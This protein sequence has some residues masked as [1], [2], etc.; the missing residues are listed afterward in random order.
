MNKS[1]N[2]RQWLTTSAAC[3]GILASG[4]VDVESAPSTRN[5]DAGPIPGSA[6]AASPRRPLPDMA[7]AKWVWYPAGRTL[8]NTF[9]LFRREIELNAPPRSARGWIAADSR[10]RLEVN[11][12]RI[13]WGPAPADPRW[14]EADPVD[15]TGV[16]RAGKNVLG[17]TVLYY[18]QGDG[19]WPIG[20]P[21][22]LCR[23]EI[24]HADGR[25][26]V[27]ASDESWRALLCRAWQPGH[28]KRWYLRA[29]QEEFDARLY[30]YGW[31]RAD[32]ATNPDW[33]AAMPLAGSPNGPALA[34]QYG[35]Y[36]L[37]ID[38]GPPDVE[39][40]PRSIPLVTESMVSVQ[41]LAETHRLDWKR[42]PREYFEFRTPD[43]FRVV[44]ESCAKETSPGSWEVTL[45]GRHGSVL[46]FVLEK[47]VVGWPYFTIEAPAGTEIELLVHEAHELGGP[48]LMN[49]H[50]D[51]W[52]RFTCR[53]GVN[54]FECFDYE[55][56]RWLQ[57]HIHGNSGR[58]IVREVGVR[59]RQFPWPN[60][61]VVR[62]SEPAIQRLFDAAINTLHNSA[63]E[64][65]V[66]GMARERQQYSGDGGHQLRSIR[67]VF[68]ETR[69]PARFLTT[70]GQGLTK[71]GYF[72]DCWPAY[73]RLA[74]LMER[75]LDLTGW[76]PILDHGVQF[77]F[78][79]WLHYLDTGDLDAI[80]EPYPRLLRFA[81]YLRTLAGPE[82]LL[83]V[84]QI[85]IPSVWIDHVAY[86]AQKHKQCAFNLN[87]A[88][89]ME[90]ALAPLCRAFGDA[91]AAEA[92]TRFGR[93]LLASTVKSFWSPDRGLFVVNRPWLDREKS[94]RFCDR[95]LAT[96]I[97]FDQ[98][99]G[100]QNEPSLKMLAECPPEMGFS[101]PCNAGWRLEAL[102]K[103]GRADV[104]V[105]DF[106]KRW[107]TMDSVRLNLTLQEDWTALPDSGSQWSHCD[108][109][110][111]FLAVEGL[112]GI[113]SRAPGF[114]RA[115]VRPQL[116][117]L[118]DLEL[119]V[120]TVKGPFRFKAAGM[121]G[122]REITV[123][124]PPGCI[125]EIVLRREESITLP[126]AAGEVLAGHARY[127]LPEKSTR[128]VLKHT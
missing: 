121:P 29:L 53:E 72:L 95:S 17:A 69:L 71:D 113:R 40:R 110:P 115:E 7:P 87:T 4:G 42:P 101:Y 85:G 65:A 96:A 119:T 8:Q 22:F 23:I 66:D 98:N 106:R 27:V 93:R 86:Q 64:T 56:L 79:C 55:S 88:A 18:G 107:A 14:P 44:R 5:D 108:V 103:G 15:L 82:S 105:H 28:Y 41:R 114:A 128:L 122:S 70:W 49:S 104:I 102:A 76:G 123:E 2:R 58:A 37:G 63:Q 10:Y 112:A 61:P 80:R 31:S 83:P 120:H 67:E 30:P 100:G 78:D 43:A 125:A 73:D 54:R 26:E 21:G 24:E 33:L 35:E 1:L 12:E 74:R 117:D 32:Y 116:A 84:E 109:A 46:T 36:M 81:E 20:K 68:G 59:R 19:T 25:G 89:A 127:A 124:P 118:A 92:V 90:H 45:D 57:L 6:P 47:Q 126:P 11:G 9:I 39:L 52:S 75:Q 94:P 99:P 48:G 50:F 62:C 91:A 38:G 60:E 111:L 77:N 13:Q 51:S 3:G 34:T 97:L 16:L